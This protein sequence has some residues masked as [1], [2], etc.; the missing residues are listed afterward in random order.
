VAIRQEPFPGQW[1][2]ILN[3]EVAF[4]RT[5]AEP[6]K[7]RFREEIRI[8]L[9]EKRISGIKT[10][11]DD[12]V[13]VLVA[14]SAIIPI[15]G[16]PGWEWNQIHEVLIY[17]TNFDD[18]Y[19]IGREG[20]RDILGM[21]G[22]GA[23]NRMMI[24][25]KPDLIQGFRNSQDKTNVGIHE[26][27]HLLDKTDGAVD[28]VPGIALPASAIQP[29]LKLVHDEMRKI[30]SGHSDINPYG[31]TSEAEFFAVVSEYF[32]ENP[33]KM[34]E[35]HATLYAMLER[36]FQQDPHSRLQNVL[37]K[38]VVSNSG[39]LRRNSLCPC[40]SKKKFKDCC[41]GNT[42]SGEI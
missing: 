9:N 14:S 38:M 11:V 26:F 31:L 2:K 3:S 41:I 7:T 34:K 36:I 20:N 19:K 13:R 27:A 12:L 18:R 39:S 32:F 30:E 21:V 8:F 23:M 40:G 4:Y 33:Q 1:E 6:E 15:F 17:P 22:S 24:L 28:G 25:S 37:S 10:S 5:L 29:W 42:S 16:F 35:K